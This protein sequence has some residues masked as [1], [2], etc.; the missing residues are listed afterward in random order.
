MDRSKL[1][2]AQKNKIAKL[3]LNGAT[4]QAL[5]AKFE[6]SVSTIFNALRDQQI[7]IRPRGR[8]PQAV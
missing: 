5:A 2:T 8:Q 1:T 7:T 6:V 4:G 3:Y